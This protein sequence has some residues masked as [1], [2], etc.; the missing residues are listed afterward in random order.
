MEMKTAI[1]LES[2]IKNTYSIEP[3]LI[4][5]AKLYSSIERILF[6]YLI[7]NKTDATTFK[8]LQKLYIAKYDIPARMFKS[9][10]I[11]TQGRID[12]LKTNNK[13]YNEQRKNK[14]EKLNIKKNKIKDKL[15]SF[16][17]NRK[18]NKLKQL[19]DNKDKI[20]SVWGSKQLFR[21]QWQ[22]KDHKEWL[23][24][25]RIKR[26]HNLIIIGSHDET[27]GNS[28]CQLQTLTKLRL[29]L[30]KCLSQKHLILDVDFDKNK[31]I[32]KYLHQAIINKQAITCRVFQREDNKKWHVQLSF[33]ISND[34]IDSDNGT[35]GIDVNYNL[36]ASCSI[37]KDGNKENFASYKFDANEKNKNKNKQA[38]SDIVNKIVVRAV[39]EKKTITIEKINLK[40]V[41]K[42]KKISLICYRL[43]ISLLKTRCVKFGVLVKEVN[44]A[45]TSVIGG[46]KY[47]RRLG[48]SRHS[49]AAYTIG[50]RGLNYIENI[51]LGYICLL[52]REEKDKSL[53]AKWNIVNKRLQSVSSE[54]K[55]FYIDK[56][57]KDQTKCDLNPIYFR[58]G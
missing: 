33:Y 32:Y 11:Q 10:W 27:F 46:L 17:V 6:N 55:S 1:S 37:K 21:K 25:W 18:I 7:H 50:R 22:A 2:D 29:T 43:F 44:P 54:K 34:C 45:Y 19:N 9:L 49:S 35:I 12:A 23:E 31:K 24:R 5:Y 16:G 42:T 8:V 53:L 36:I 13:N 28:L 20:Q 15:F 56:I 14:I 30:P 48:V 51:P 26:D 38:L 4:S 58:Y 39:D 41:A 40:N 3:V 52:H 47:N 57:Y